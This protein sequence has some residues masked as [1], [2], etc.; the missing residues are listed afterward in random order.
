MPDIIAN[1][2][3]ALSDNSNRIIKNSYTNAVGEVVS[4]LL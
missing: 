2:V 3:Y 4:N 1:Q